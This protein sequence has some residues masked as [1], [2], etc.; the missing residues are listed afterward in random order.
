MP[1][2]VIEEIVNNIT[3]NI[4]EVVSTYTIEVSEMQVPGA[5]GKS[6]Y[7]SAIDGGFVGTELEFNQSLS[8]VNIKSSFA[9]V[10]TYALMLAISLP[11]ELKIVKVLNDE[12]K[13]IENTIY[14]IYPDG[15]RMWIASVQDN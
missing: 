5:D 6:A 4:D 14:H 2:I 11:N 12:N 10:N 9:Q 8:N 1:N 13:G 3:L 15:V 7:Q